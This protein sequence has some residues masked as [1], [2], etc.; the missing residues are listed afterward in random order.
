MLDFYSCF[1]VAVEMACEM[2]GL[3]EDDPRGLTVTGGLPYAGGPGNDYTLHS[4]ATMMNRLR[5]QPGAAGLVTGNGWYLTKH[6]AT[7]V[8]SAPRE[9]GEWSPPGAAPEDDVPAETRATAPAEGRGTIETYTVL[10]DREGAPKRG[11]IVGRSKAGRR[12]VANTAEDRT[13]LEGL[14][15]EEAVGRTGWV[16]HQDGRNVFDPG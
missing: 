10:Y 6:S 4:L 1:P 8:A 5:Q 9:H 12:F 7:V 15:S 3:E 11:V 16:S 14:V 13:V 2:L